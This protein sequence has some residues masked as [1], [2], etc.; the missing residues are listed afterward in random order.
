MP[1]KENQ[2]KKSA[3]SSR[4]MSNQAKWLFRRNELRELTLYRSEQLAHEKLHAI[5]S[6]HEPDQIGARHQEHIAH[7]A[8]SCQMSVPHFVAILSHIV[9]HVE[10]FQNS[11][12]RDSQR[13]K[14]WNHLH[15]Y[16][17]LRTGVNLR[18]GKLDRKYNRW[19]RDKNSA[20][21]VAKPVTYWTVER[22]GRATKLLNSRNVTH[23]C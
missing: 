11:R 3:I 9:S 14:T 22:P 2:N 17:M 13:M 5:C 10:I 20:T 8:E 7:S 6:N 21:S 15:E 4:Q 1:P 12:N 16:S 18:K 19:P 23:L